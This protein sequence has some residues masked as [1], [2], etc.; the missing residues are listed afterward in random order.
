M[1]TYDLSNE[2]A[3]V[4]GALGL[5]GPVWIEGLLKSGARVIA[6]DLEQARIS[7]EFNRLVKE[8]GKDKLTLYR[9][10][11]TDR[12]SL[13]RILKQSQREVGIATILVN[14]A[15]IDQPPTAL[16][17]GYYFEDLPFEIGE[18]ILEVNVL[19]SF[20]MIQVFGSEMVKNKKGS[21]IN[22]GSMYA[23]ISPDPAVYDHI[24][25]DPPFLKPPMYGPSK[26][27]ILNLTKY[28]AV[29]W[30][31]HNVRINAISPGAIFNNQ[32]PKFIKKI[33][34]KIPLKR[35]G[36]NDDIVGPML[37]LAS[38]A[39]KYIT[40]ENIKVDGGITAL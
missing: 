19:G 21:I 9:G 35:M 37:F 36:Y 5:L 14:N 1:T 40:G 33:T 39:S 13:E 26:A 18:K 29:L 32:D 10:D 31:P 8:Y 7:T 4:T 22:L 34:A 3:V 15:G 16:K 6:I 12:K 2:I 28:V 27:A 25:T 20:Q 38:D 30:G 11:V 17:K 23:S 24:K